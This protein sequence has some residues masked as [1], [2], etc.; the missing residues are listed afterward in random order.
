[1]EKILPNAREK[2]YGVAC[3]RDIFSIRIICR[4]N[5]IL[6]LL[7]DMSDYFDGKKEWDE[8]EVPQKITN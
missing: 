1:M 3:N 4:A 8:D 6:E 2:S 7:E 5:K